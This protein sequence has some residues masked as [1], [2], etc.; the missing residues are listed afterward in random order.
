MKEF[1]IQALL[2]RNFTKTSRY[3]FANIFCLY[4]ELNKELDFLLIDDKGLATE[5]EIKCSREDFTSEFKDKTSKHEK[6][7]GRD[8][9]CPNRYNII[10]PERVA[11]LEEIPEYAGFIELQEQKD[12]TYK[13][14]IWKKAPLL[15][16]GKMEPRDLFDKLYYRYFNHEQI[17]YN[18][19]R[20]RIRKKD[21]IAPP[22]V[23]KAK[24]V[25]RSRRRVTR[26]VKRRG[27][28]DS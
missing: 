21:G 24:K 22:K 2:W 16:S 15:H 23:S 12:G 27:S 11:K 17:R 28:T 9:T 3:M 8:P 19:D 14:K 6:L 20:K 10:A 13:Y 18:N 25:G 5:F 4:G 26:R 7:A 1:D